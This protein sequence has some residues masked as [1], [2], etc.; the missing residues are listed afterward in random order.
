MSIKCKL[1]MHNWNGCICKSCKKNRN[2]QHDFSMDCQECSICKT[3]VDLEH[4]WDKLGLKCIKC[5]TINFVKYISI[6]K[7]ESKSSIEKLIEDNKSKTKFTNINFNELEEEVL[8]L[9]A[10]ENISSI[11]ALMKVVEYS[12]KLKGKDP[13][14][15]I[16]KHVARYG[17]EKD[18]NTLIKAHVNINYETGYPTFTLLT[19]ALYFDNLPVAHTLINAGADLECMIN[20]SDH[21]YETALILAIKKRFDETALLLIKAGAKIEAIDEKGYSAL[22]L[23]LIKNERE[24]FY[25]LLKSGANAKTIFFHPELSMIFKDGKDGFDFGRP[26]AR[27]YAINDVNKLIQGDWSMALNIN[28]YWKYI[29]ENSRWGRTYLPS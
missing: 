16:I 6:I 12:S 8:K 26:H 13:L 11:I 23:S 14:H 18:V 19:Y 10:E 17:S 27:E 3:T 9:I 15:T 28:N 25:T 21:Y 7:T 2:E 4:E 20:S 29:S 24:I 1:G 22:C 5:N